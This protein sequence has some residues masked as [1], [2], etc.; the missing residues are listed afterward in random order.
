MQLNQDSHWGAHT[1]TRW[2]QFVALGFRLGG[3]NFAQHSQLK[4]CFAGQSSGLV[5][6]T[7][8]HAK[9]DTSIRKY[10]N[11]LTDLPARI[12]FLGN[13]QRRKYTKWC[14]LDKNYLHFEHYLYWVHFC[15]ELRGW[16][17]LRQWWNRAE[18]GSNSSFV[19]LLEKVQKR[20]DLKV[21]AI[22]SNFDNYRALYYLNK[23]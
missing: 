7:G 6:S 23:I 5:W 21:A 2:W 4:W 10:Q 18:P 15:K 14:Q 9:S 22:I 17:K 13:W 20:P 3:A 8:C 16:I 12:S 11:R 1:R 19:H